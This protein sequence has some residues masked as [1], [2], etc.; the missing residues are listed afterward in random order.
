[1]KD[2]TDFSLFPKFPGTNQLVVKKISPVQVGKF[3]EFRRHIYS[4][5]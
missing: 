1:M 3:V 5:T 4:Q 2:L